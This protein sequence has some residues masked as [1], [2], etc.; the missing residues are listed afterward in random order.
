MEPGIEN[1][2]SSLSELGYASAYLS[3][4]LGSVY[5][6]AFITA[7]VLTISF[8]LELC[9]Y[10]PWFRNLNL[11]IKK[12]LHWNFVIRLLIEAAMEISFGTY[13]QIKYGEFNFKLFGSWFNF[14]STAFLGGSL[15]LLPIFIVI[16]YNHNFHKLE[17][18]EF[19]AKYGAVYEGLKKKKKIVLFY[20]VYFIIKRIGFAFSSLM[21]YDYPLF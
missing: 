7:L 5:V 20:P 8:I 14:V 12:K 2:R 10:D 21:L 9:S 17:N 4:N 11:W 19:E 18:E 15:V 16:F 1:L 3:N 6:F 13:L